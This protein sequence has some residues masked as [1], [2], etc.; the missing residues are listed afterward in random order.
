[1]HAPPPPEDDLTPKKEWV[2]L[3]SDEALSAT[4][5]RELD[6]HPLVA[7]ILIQRGLHTL[8]QA[9]AFL[10]PNLNQMHDPFLMKGMRQAVDLILEAVNQGQRIVIH[11]DYDVDGISSAA[12]VYEF[13]RDI[14]A[15]SAFFIPR[16]SKEGY[17]LTIETIRR[18]QHEGAEVLI[19][20]DCGISSVDEIVLAKAL[21]MQVVVVDHHT[22]PQVL[23]PADAILN[24]LQPGCD[25]P[26][27]KLAA[28]GVA[29]N[30][31]VALRSELRARGVFEYVPQPDLRSYLD[32]VALGTIADVVPL[33]DEN[34]LFAR[35]GL[36]ELSKRKRA[37]V[38]ALFERACNDLE[39]ATTQTV[40][41]QLAPR[42]N[43]AGR[44][45]DASI[46]VDLLTTRSY[47][48]AVQLAGQLEQM[49][50]DRQVVEREIMHEAMIQAE[51]QV[52][53]ELPILIVYGENWNR[54]VL[55][56]VASRLTEKYGRPSLLL[57]L[58]DGLGKGSARS[59]A[60]IN[61]IEALTECADLLQ[62]FGGHVSAAGV[63]LPARHLAE[64]CTRMPEVVARMLATGLPRPKLTLSGEVEL[65]DLDQH[66]FE[67]LQRLAPFGMAN[68][69]PI[70]L[71]RPLR[72]TRARI[73]GKRHLR[74]RF[75]DVRSQSIEGIGFSMASA[76][77]KLERAEVGVAFV[78]RLSIRQATPRLEMHMKDIRPIG[79]ASPERVEL[80]TPQP[81][82]ALE[83]A[84]QMS[85]A[86][87][88][89][90]PLRRE[91]AARPL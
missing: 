30:L 66:V 88:P 90:A 53:S 5:A 54:G 86:A 84:Q 12:V 7:P 21:G 24:P 62:S 18:L 36:D 10:N 77:P 1:M 3:K 51:E 58:E 76:K 79:E 9:R 89:P 60:G 44:M 34:R 14:G 27:K 49:N 38:A 80:I 32:L 65:E 69:E 56:I 83:E 45:G 6:I 31:V 16:R 70:F 20:T 15:D 59:T 23:P 61:L 74:A 26:F 39:V 67:D 17:G 22:V 73:V 55:G 91:G 81:D 82:E 47:A 43:A 48:E 25:F 37:G 13:L 29:F 8:E 11:G 46:C 42:L 68:P 63:T 57:G 75:Y 78:P 52:A 19:T 4:F 2:L 28:V 71:S 40:S 72:P 85:S 50:K 87:P 33:V 35:F 64:F 41:F